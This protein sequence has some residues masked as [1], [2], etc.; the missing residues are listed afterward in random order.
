M[1]SHVKLFSDTLKRLRGTVSQA[2]IAR[3]CG[4][5]QSSYTRYESG[6]VT[7]KHDALCKIAMHYGLTVDQLLAG[8]E[9]PRRS[10]PGSLLPESAAD[11]ATARRLAAPSITLTQRERVAQLAVAGYD[12]ASSRHK[13]AQYETLMQHVAGVAEGNESWQWHRDEAGSIMDK[14]FGEKNDSQTH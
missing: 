3:L 2:E 14:H 9:E 1:N 6:A 11:H 12:A 4:I 8:G 7:P 13:A 5:P 10:T